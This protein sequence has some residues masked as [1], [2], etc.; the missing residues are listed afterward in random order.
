MRTLRGRAVARFERDAFAVGGD[1][2]RVGGRRQPAEHLFRTVD[3]DERQIESC[4][5][6]S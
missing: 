5:G 1:A 3:I 4:R 2:R 6:E